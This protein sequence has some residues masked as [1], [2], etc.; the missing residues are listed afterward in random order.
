MPKN[1]GIG[2]SSVFENNKLDAEP[3]REVNY[4]LVVDGTNTIVYAPSLLTQSDLTE[5]TAEGW[6]YVD[7]TATGGYQVYMSQMGYS[8]DWFGWYVAYFSGFGQGGI[9]YNTYPLSA[10]ATTI[11]QSAVSKDQF[12]HFCAYWNKNGDQKLHVA[13]NGV[14]E[15]SFLLQ[16]TGGDDN[17]W[18]QPIYFGNRYDHDATYRFKGKLSW[19]R[20]ST[21]DRHGHGVDFTPP[22]M[23]VVPD[24][25]SNTVG[26]WGFNDGAGNTAYDFSSNR[27]DAVISDGTWEAI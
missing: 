8:L 22:V 4:V 24:T 1:I 11:G 15:T 27:S 12:I 7:S 13:T 17:G 20:I 2:I 26:L 3:S 14:W 19:Q 18:S 10:H 9:N 25:D 21:G 6:Y 16:S 5:F 23:S